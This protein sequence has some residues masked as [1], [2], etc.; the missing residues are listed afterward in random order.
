[1][2]I[3]M[4]C[5]QPRSRRAVFTVGDVELQRAQDRLAAL[6]EELA[7]CQDRL[8][9]EHR[10]A[11]EI[12]ARHDALVCHVAQITA[13]RN[14]AHAARLAAEEDQMALEL[15]VERL[16]AEV[17]E[18]RKL[19]RQLHERRQPRVPIWQRWRKRD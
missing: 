7:A 12:S 19:A 18:L 14:S 4:G 16:T 5:L 13:E 17:T 11:E 8:D 9:A 3:A 6:G 1:M 2:R 10:R 15:Q